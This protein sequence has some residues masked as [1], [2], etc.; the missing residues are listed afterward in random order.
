[1]Q[2]I[3]RCRVDGS[4][5]A[6][7]FWGAGRV[8]LGIANRSLDLLRRRAAHRI[9]DLPCRRRAAR[10]GGEP[11]RSAVRRLPPSPTAGLAG[12]QRL[13]RSVPFAERREPASRAAKRASVMAS[14]SAS[15]PATAATSRCSGKGGTSLAESLPLVLPD[16]QDRWSSPAARSIPRSGPQRNGRYADLD[17]AFCLPRQG[18]RGQ[19]F[20]QRQATGSASVRVKGAVQRPNLAAGRHRRHRQRADHLLRQQQQDR[21]VHADQHVL[22]RMVAPPRPRSRSRPRRR[23]NGSSRWPT[24]TR[25][26]RDPRRDRRA[27]AAR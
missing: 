23:P 2:P 3:L 5:A 27:Q 18:E 15:A 14:C 17:N 21:R 1:M 25:P 7:L 24:I 22:Q 4:T 16:R 11:V 13:R 12:E 6:S 20:L 10:V 8:V 9:C 26:G 19:L